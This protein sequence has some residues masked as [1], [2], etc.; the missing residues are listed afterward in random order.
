MSVKIRLTRGGSKKRP[1]YRIVVANSRSPRDGKFIEVIGTYNPLLA[2]D[3]EKRFVVNIDAAQNWLSKGALPTETV[4]KIMQLKGVQL[5]QA[6]VSKIEKVKN[7]PQKL[8][9]KEAKA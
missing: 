4:A 3:H 1:F 7:N 2:K 5:P 8:S 9:K 6:I